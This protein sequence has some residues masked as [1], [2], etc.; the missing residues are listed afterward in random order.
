MRSSRCRLVLARACAG[1]AYRNSDCAWAVIEEAERGISPA[2]YHPWFQSSSLPIALGV[3]RLHPDKDFATLIRRF[4]RLRQHT[5]VGLVLKR[6]ELEG[7]THQ[8]SVTEDVLFTS[9]EPRPPALTEKCSVFM[10]PSIRK[11]SALVLAETLS[12]GMP[13][14]S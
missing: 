10:L 7:L 6:S 2:V 14:R 12:S 13:C 9:Y 4:V 8:L 5:M 3:G 1:L 11:S